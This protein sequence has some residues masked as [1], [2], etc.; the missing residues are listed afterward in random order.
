MSVALH[1][2]VRWTDFSELWEELVLSIFDFISM[3]FA[4]AGGIYMIENLGNPPG[5]YAFVS[6]PILIPLNSTNAAV[7]LTS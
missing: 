6:W 7:W 4:F 5:W 3:V 2:L 1:R